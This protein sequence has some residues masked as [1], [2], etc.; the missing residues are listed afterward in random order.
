MRKYIIFLVLLFLCGCASLEYVDSKGGVL[1]YRR[2]GAQSIQGLTMTI[3][4][5]GVATI[6]IEKNKADAGDL[7]KAL[8]DLAAVAAKAGTT[9]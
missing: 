2:W 9:P 7:G 8:A 1:R 6:R 3:D 4:E 5:N